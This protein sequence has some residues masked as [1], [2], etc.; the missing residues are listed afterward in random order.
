MDSSDAY[1]ME[2][3]EEALRLDVKTDPDA[4]RKQVQICGIGPGCRVLDGGCGSGR[5]H[6]LSMRWFS[7]M[8]LSWG[9]ILPGIG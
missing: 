1:L 5:Q 4:V 7:L 6:P 8:V 3:S 9:S 2:D